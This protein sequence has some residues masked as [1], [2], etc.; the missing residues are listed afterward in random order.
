MKTGLLM[1]AVMS[2]QLLSGAERAFVALDN[3]LGGIAAPEEQ[4]KLLKELGYAGIC[5]RMGATTPEFLAAFD[6]H[7]VKITASYVVLPAGP[8]K[9]EAPPNA[10]AHFASLK[11]RDTVIWLGVQN[12]KASLEE[13]VAL[14]RSVCDRA[15]EH[16]LSVVLYPHVGFYTDTVAACVDLHRA[17]QHANLGLSVTL[18]HFLALHPHETLEETLRSL[19][20]HLKL[21]QINGA[22]EL[23]APK[24]DWKRL[25]QPLGQGSFDVGRVLKTLDEIGYRG[26][27]ALQCFQVP[28]PPR[29]H[30]GASINAWK[31]LNSRD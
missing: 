25:I 13:A 5:T 22:D 28:G 7:G 27:V 17:V 20:P 8:G 18:C 1:V 12:K 10:V 9:S 23:P 11:G 3:G 2:A 24:A 4:A 19:A 26:A 30:L 6:R 15:A 16:G 14:T 31:Q 21:V 29:E